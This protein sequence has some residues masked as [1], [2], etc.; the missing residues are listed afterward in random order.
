[1]YERNLNFKK[2]VQFILVWTQ[3][4]SARILHV[5]IDLKMHETLRKPIVESGDA[6]VVDWLLNAVGS[7]RCNTRRLFAFLLILHSDRIDLQVFMTC[8]L[9]VLKLCN[10]QLIL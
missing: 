8:S 1:M 5:A 2:N 4:V 7:S 10:N 6:L 9:M 3:L